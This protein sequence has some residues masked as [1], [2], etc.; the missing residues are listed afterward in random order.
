MDLLLPGKVSG[1][2][3]VFHSVC[4]R[5]PQANNCLEHVFPGQH[6]WLC[7]FARFAGTFAQ[8][9]LNHKKSGVFVED[10]GRHWGRR[11][12]RS[13]FRLEDTESLFQVKNK[14]IFQLMDLRLPGKRSGGVHVFHSVF[15]RLPQ[16]HDWFG[17]V[18]PGQHPWPSIFAR[19]AATF[20]QIGHKSW[21]S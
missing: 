19:F 12:H 8:I 18:F 17:H 9:G 14:N 21:K 16:K 15:Q 10:A 1:G 13:R 4:Q 3:Q 7:I 11:A 2:V 5:L 6:P 20:A